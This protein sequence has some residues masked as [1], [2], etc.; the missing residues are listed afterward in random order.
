M[1]K[2]FRI[3]KREECEMILLI[4]LPAAGKTTWANKHVEANPEKR[5]NVI[6]TNALIEKMKVDSNQF[7][8][9]AELCLIAN[10]F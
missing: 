10:V 9:I 5:Y 6:G 3:A 8:L 7:K 2:Y 1:L 4:G